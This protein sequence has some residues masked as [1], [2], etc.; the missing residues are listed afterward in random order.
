MAARLMDAG[1]CV[2]S[3]LSHSHPISA[4]CKVDATDHEY[5]MRQDLPWLECC[6]IFAFMSIPGW[7]GE[8]NQA[9]RGR[10]GKDTL[11][12]TSTGGDHAKMGRN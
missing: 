12:T 7:T 1:Y 11:R 2:F 4:H 6:D 9:D 10:D 5:W 8:Q 3:P